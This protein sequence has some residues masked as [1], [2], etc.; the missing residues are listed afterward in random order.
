M[1]GATAVSVSP[2]LPLPATYF[3]ASD[4]SAVIALDAR[5]FVVADDEDNVLRMYDRQKPGWPVFNWDSSQFL[6]V[7]RRSPESDLEGAARIG[8]RVYWITSHGRNKNGELRE[9]RHRLFATAI[10]QSPPGLSP[11]GKPY[12]DLNQD[13][14][15]DPRLR[16]LGLSLAA[17]RAPKSPGAFNIEGLSATP[18]GKLLIGFRNPVPFGR[19]LVV[20][21]LNPEKVIEGS[22]AEL[23]A[24]ILLNLQGLGIRSMTWIGDR[25]LILAGS[26][27]SSGPHVLFDWKGAGEPVLVRTLDLPGF[28]PEGMDLIP[29]ASFLSVLIVSDDGT[30]KVGRKMNKRLRIQQQK[31][32]RMMELAL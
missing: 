7:D 27:E 23:G 9:S 11:M 21:L 25:Y 20:P 14:T 2:S 15:E 19:A 32:F 12:L 4:A 1:A 26:Y 29:D 18:D 31:R 22:R 3:G 8:D 16:T 5:H 28:N 13:L 30:Q 6:K 24:P 17:T 10:S